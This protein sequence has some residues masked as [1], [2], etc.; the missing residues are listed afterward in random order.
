MDTA[1]INTVK[2]QERG[3][4]CA[5]HQM[6]GGSLNYTNVWLCRTFLAVWKDLSYMQIYSSK[7]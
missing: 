1:L 2:L 3:R 4:H 6:L 7:I 5:V